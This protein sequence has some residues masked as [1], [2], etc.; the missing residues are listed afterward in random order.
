[1]FC[2]KFRPVLQRFAPEVRAVLAPKLARPNPTFAGQIR[3]YPGYKK[4]GH[5]REVEPLITKITLAIFGI[6]MVGTMLDWR[7]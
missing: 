7:W 4:F 3:G 6:L 1:M 5:K 2:S